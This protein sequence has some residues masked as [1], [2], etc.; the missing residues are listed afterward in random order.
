MPRFLPKTIPDTEAVLQDPSLHGA[1]LNHAIN[2]C[3]RDMSEEFGQFLGQTPSWYSMAIYASRGAGKGM[4]AAARA[5]Q[6]VEGQQRPLQAVQK[7][8]PGVPQSD[9][10]PFLSVDEQG[11]N[12]LGQATSFLLAFFLAQQEGDQ[13][14]SLDPRVLTISASRLAKLLDQ[15]GVNL[16]CV[17][18]TIAA[19]LEDGNRR[20]FQDIGVSG[21]RY[22]EL[23][24][25]QPGLPPEGVLQHFQGST[26]AYEE[27]LRRAEGQQEI[28]TEYSQFSS[29]S[30]MGSGF[31]LYQRSALEAD[32]ARR[33]RLASQASNMLAWHEQFSVAVPAFFPAEILPGEADRAQVMEILTPQ[34]DVKTHNWTWHYSQFEQ[35]DLDDSW[36]TPPCSERNWARFEDRWPPILDYFARCHQDPSALWPMPNPDPG[37]PLS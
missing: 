34:I 17:A 10:A 4:L 24:R 26:Q 16:A 13:R 36:W 9:W 2:R 18:R 33:A 7:A 22:L 31:A 29:Q 14:L 25:D 20:I 32:P 19:T 12:S 37:Q 1:Q 23:R 8:F 15:P 6:V 30:L 3:Y 5:L 21:Q 35:P 11:G 27:A 28:P